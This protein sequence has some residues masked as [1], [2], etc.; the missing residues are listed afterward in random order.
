VAARP[1]R[2]VLGPTPPVLVVPNGIDPDEWRVTPVPH[3]VDEVH[4]VAVMRL[5]PRKRTMPLLEAI[6]D[7]AEAVP[8]HVRLRATVVGDGP[9]RSQVEKFVRDQH[10]AGVIALPGRL[11]HDGIRELYAHADV[12]VQPSVK[13][14]FGLAALEARTAGLPVVARRETGI[15]EFVR[16]GVEGLI[17]GSDAQLAAAI[18]RLA[19]DAPLRTR[20]GAHNR[21]VLPDQVWPHVLEIVDDAY[22]QAAALARRAG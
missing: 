20:I 11:S 18:A 1:I 21:D 15:T 22:G 8:V 6:R 7:A 4:V 10:L 12:F 9:M 14:S 16:D 2:E 13:E 3:D 17:V 19:S 5:A